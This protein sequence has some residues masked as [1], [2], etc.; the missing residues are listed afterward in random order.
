MVE[1]MAIKNKQTQW[2]HEQMNKHVCHDGKHN[3]SKNR[4]KQTC[5]S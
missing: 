1:A 5:V 2:L 3:A 4:N